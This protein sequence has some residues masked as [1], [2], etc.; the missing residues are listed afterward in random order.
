MSAHGVSIKGL[1]SKLYNLTSKK[2]PIWLKTRQETE[3]TLFRRRYTT[4]GQETHETMFNITGHQGNA[5]QNQTI[6]RHYRIPVRIAITKKTTNKKCWRGCGKKGSLVQ[7]R[8][9]NTENKLV[10]ATGEWVRGMSE[11]G[12]G[13]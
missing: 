5:N 6:V 12:E 11:I 1:I 3:Q 9:T 4:D 7:N 13:D 10:A 2:N 8:L